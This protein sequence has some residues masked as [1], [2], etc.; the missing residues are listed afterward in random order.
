MINGMQGHQQGDA[1]WKREEF[2]PQ[3]HGEHVAEVFNK[4][5]VKQLQRELA[6]LKALHTNQQEYIK[7]LQQQ[8]LELLKKL[9]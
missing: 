9:S 8:N 1:A 4:Q 7:T 2:S 5:R 6:Q 3:K